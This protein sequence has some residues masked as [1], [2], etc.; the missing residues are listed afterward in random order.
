LL[1]DGKL[2]A[3]LGEAGRRR[4]EA[5]FDIKKMVDK[6]EALLAEISG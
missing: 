4:A 1:Q 5:F 2:A 6:I 3:T